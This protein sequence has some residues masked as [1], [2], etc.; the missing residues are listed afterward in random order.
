MRRQAFTHTMEAAQFQDA[1]TK[2]LRSMRQSRIQAGASM[3]RRPS[4]RTDWKARY[5]EVAA[6]LDACE[7]CL[8]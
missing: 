3:K 5:E 4:K 8:E 7:G 2:S 1:E 6:D